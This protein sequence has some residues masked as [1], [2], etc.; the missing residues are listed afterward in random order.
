MQMYLYLYRVGTYKPYSCCTQNFPL[1]RYHTILLTQTNISILLEYIHV[2]P[3]QTFLIKGI[4][5][6]NLKSHLLNWGENH[7]WNK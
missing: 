7:Q 2:L 3:F 5:N 4:A 6:H 1:N